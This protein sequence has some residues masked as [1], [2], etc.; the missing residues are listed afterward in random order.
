MELSDATEETPATPEIDPRT[1]RL[2]SQRLNHYAT[3]GPQAGG[4][5]KGNDKIGHRE[6]PLIR[7]NFTF[8]LET[9]VSICKFL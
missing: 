2:V 5:K 8:Y 6:T 4:S 3:Q 1:F 9:M 7:K